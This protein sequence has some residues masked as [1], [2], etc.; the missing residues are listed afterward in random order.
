[1]D[2]TNVKFYNMEK[3]DIG[4]MNTLCVIFTVSHKV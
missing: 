1:M 4:Y 3:L 2:P